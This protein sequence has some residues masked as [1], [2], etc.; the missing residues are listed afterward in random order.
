[1]RAFIILRDFL[2]LIV[3]FSMCLLKV[4]F[5]S[6]VSPKIF[7]WVSVGRM[8]LSIFNRSWLLY[9]AGSG[10]NRVVIVFVAFSSRSLS[11]VHLTISSRY[12]FSLSWMVS[13]FLSEAYIVMSSA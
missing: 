13:G 3:E 1:M 10:V 4:S 8:V 6:K 5:G 12:G 11:F 9:S 7:G 2:A